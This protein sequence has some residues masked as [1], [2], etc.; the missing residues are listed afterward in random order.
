[1]AVFDF[2]EACMRCT[3]ENYMTQS[4]GQFRRRVAVSKVEGNASCLP[5]GRP[6]PVFTG[7]HGIQGPSLGSRTDKQEYEHGRRGLRNRSK[8]DEMKRFAGIDIG[9]ERHVVAVVDEHGALLIKP[10]PFSE[11]AGGYRRLVELLGPA[12][13][14]LVAMEATGHY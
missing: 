2:I 9:S 7:S 10:T 1:M 6:R 3:V 14:C 4:K 11:E 5:D 12:A 13:D 8:R